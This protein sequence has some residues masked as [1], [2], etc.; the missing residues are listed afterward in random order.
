MV[1]KGIENQQLLLQSIGAAGCSA[2]FNI[3]SLFRHPNMNLDICF[4]MIFPWG[5]IGS[6]WENLQYSPDSQYHHLRNVVSYI[7]IHTSK[8]SSLISLSR[9]CIRIRIDKIKGQSDTESMKDGWCIYGM[10]LL[11]VR[12]WAVMSWLGTITIVFLVLGPQSSLFL[13]YPGV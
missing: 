9:C 7:T 1:F 10:A 11:F 4:I 2:F 8:F 6:P 12:D 5:Q 3:R 13:F